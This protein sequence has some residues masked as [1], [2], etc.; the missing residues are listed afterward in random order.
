MIIK[1]IGK[2][3]WHDRP[4]THTT[5]YEPFDDPAHIQAGVNFALSQD[6]TGL[7]TAGDLK[8]LPYFLHACENFTPLDA[9]A[10]EALIATAGQYESVFEP[11]AGGLM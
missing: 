11:G 3:L 4:H 6:V 8:I 10:Q 7:C 2:G 5:W 9:A 1:A